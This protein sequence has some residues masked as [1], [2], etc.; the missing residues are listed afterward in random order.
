MYVQVCV[1]IVLVCILVNEC[2][3]VRVFVSVHVCDCTKAVSWCHLSFSIALNLEHTNLARL[4][5]LQAPGILPSPPPQCWG[6]RHGLSTGPYPCVSGT[7]L[8]DSSPQPPSLHFYTFVFSHVWGL[9]ATESDAPGSIFTWGN[10]IKMAEF[11]PLFPKFSGWSGTV[12]SSSSFQ[13]SLYEN[14]SWM[15]CH[16]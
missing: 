7:L 11:K 8:T 13:G 4:S 16:L 12:I 2:V 3:C 9:I 14:M 10:S 6:Y 15:E 5:G 1:C